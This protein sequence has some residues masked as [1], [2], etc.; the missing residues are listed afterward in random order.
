MKNIKKLLVVATILL[1]TSAINAQY[2]ISATEIASLNASSVEAYLIVHGWDTSPMTINGV[3]SYK[4]TYN[5]TDVHGDPTIASG[6]LH[7]PQLCDTMPLVSYQHG[8]EFEKSTIPSNNYYRDIG[9]FYSGNGYITTMPDYLG[10]GENPGIHPYVHWESE[11]TASIELIRASREFL[12]DSL[13]I[14]DNNQLFLAGYSQG[15]HSAMA[16]HKYITINNLQSEFNVVASAPMSGPYALSSVEFDRIF[17]EDSTYS[18]S[19]FIPYIFASYQMVYG[20]LYTNYNEYYDPPY[21]TQI[22]L[23]LAGSYTAAQWAA[24]IPYNY[25]DFIQ[26]SVI[27][28]IKN[29]PNHPFNIALRENDLYSWV[30]E[31]PVRMLYCGMDPMVFPE[32]SIMA[33]DTMNALGATDVQAI[34]MDPSGNHFTCFKP[35]FFYALEWFDSLR[36][37]CLMVSIPSPKEKPEISLYPNPVKD[38]ARFSSEEITSIEIYNMMGALIIRQNDNKVDMSGL[39]SGVYFV[40]GIDK[41]NEALYKGRVIKN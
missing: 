36:V 5:T 32:N 6:A 12:T 10:L 22:A 18:W 15:G 7:V 27:Y 4:I 2:L 35:A 1:I 23:Y 25:Y 24:L 3:I 20:N 37:E 39:K 40:I 29:N 11:A 9:L 8:T 34:E 19:E 16:I 33:Q 14:R 41:N 30:P 31:E 38:I 17:N 26:D 13:L 21:D 28:N